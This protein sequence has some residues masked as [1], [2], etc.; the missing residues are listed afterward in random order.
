M[1]DAEKLIIQNITI[2]PD[3]HRNEISIHP[4]AQQKIRQTCIMYVGG[5]LMTTHAAV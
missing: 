4:Q 3:L 5:T 2:K 1:H